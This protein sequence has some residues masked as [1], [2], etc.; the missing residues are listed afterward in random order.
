MQSSKYPIF[1]NRTVVAAG[2]PMVRQ[3]LKRG[4]SDSA[5]DFL[6]ILD[7]GRFVITEAKSN[8]LGKAKVQLGKTMGYI[9]E[10]GTGEVARVEVALKRGQRIGG[11]FDIQDGVNGIV[12]D[13]DGNPVMIDVLDGAGNSVVP[14][15][16]PLRVVWYN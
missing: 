13:V 14:N 6:S 9:R 2:D 1:K 10:L 3:L 12:R 11:G 8:D 15:A 16:M 4:P 5:A 7:S